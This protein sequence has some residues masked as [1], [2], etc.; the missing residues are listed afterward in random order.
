[1]KTTTPPEP[2]AMTDTSGGARPRAKTMVRLD[3]YNAYARL[4]VSPLL[5]TDEIKEVINRKR[6]EVMRQRR[7]RGEQQFGE[8]EAEMTRLQAIEDEIGTP[9]ARAR[10]DR[11]NPQNALLTIQPGLHDVCLDSKHRAGLATAWVVEQLGHASSLP[12][13]ESIALWA[14]QGLDTDLVAFLT[15]FA[16]ANNREADAHEVDEA[17]LPDIAE[18]ERFGFAASSQNG[19]RAAG[20][21]SQKRPSRGQLRGGSSDG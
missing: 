20:E 17:E 13:P 15:S 2:L 21:P 6:K 16:A 3:L 11:L 7:T 14:S 10:Y 12:S 18:L 5:P 9:K 4:G 19:P 1:M 8:E